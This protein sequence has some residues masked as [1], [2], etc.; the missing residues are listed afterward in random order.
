MYLETAMHTQG[1]RMCWL[2]I[3]NELRIQ[4]MSCTLNNTQRT[5]LS[6]FVCACP[7]RQS[8]TIS[9]LLGIPHTQSIHLFI[10]PSI[11]S[12]IGLFCHLSVHP[13]I[14]LC[15]HLSIYLPIYQLCPVD[16]GLSDRLSSS[17]LSRPPTHLTSHSL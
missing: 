14:C 6:D 4:P 9:C 15:I 11:S 10:Y 12:F 3:L 13:F 1:R 5:V 7:F 2:A 17:K 8:Q 16:H